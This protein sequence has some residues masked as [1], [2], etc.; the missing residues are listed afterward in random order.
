MALE[1]R[2]ARREARGKSKASARKQRIEAAEETKMPGPTEAQIRQE[3]QR[4]SEQAGAIAQASAMEAA[5]GLMGGGVS[6][7]RAQELVGG[8]TAALGEQAA[9][10]RLG[11]RELLTQI[12]D[13][14]R[15]AAKAR[16]DQLNRD[17]E[18]RKKQNMQTGMQAAGLAVE[19]GGQVAQMVPFMCWVA[20][21][22]IPNDWM[23]ARV[24]M[25]CLA[26]TWFRDFYLKY[27]EQFADYISDKP[28]IKAVL[29]PLFLGFA[30]RGQRFL[31]DSALTV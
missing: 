25:N 14:R 12:A 27:G 2:L 29:R 4:G 10:S 7:G 21:E 26:P 15:Q 6:A 23:F 22:V 16:L 3:A 28:L 31:R 11:A 30:R 17:N 20:R 8:T 24:Y 5:Q 13:T 9:Q 19:V 18:I 1:D